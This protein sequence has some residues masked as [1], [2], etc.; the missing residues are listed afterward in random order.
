MLFF[1]QY[2]AP[3]GGG[4]A[5]VYAAVG[6]YFTTGGATSATLALPAGLSAGDL[7]IAFLKVNGSFGTSGTPAGWSKIGQFDYGPGSSGAWYYRFWQAGDTA[8]N[9]TWTGSLSAGGCIARYT[10][11]ASVGA[12]ST[13]TSGFASPWT[14][15]ALTTTKANSLVVL[16][17]MADSGSQ[18]VGAGGSWSSE[19]NQLDNVYNTTHAVAGRVLA[20]SG[21][22]CGTTSTTDANLISEWGSVAIELKN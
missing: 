21:S 9:I 2:A 16:S 15:A 1:E 6:T 3:A 11:A 22:S 18:L 5:P 12:T 13:I 4:A 14:S 20:S 17:G 7:M 19:F 10:G 8:P